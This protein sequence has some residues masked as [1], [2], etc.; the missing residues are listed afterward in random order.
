MPVNAVGF[1]LER[2]HMMKQFLLYMTLFALLLTT[3]L[4]SGCSKPSGEDTGD[5]NEQELP[6]KEANPEE[7]HY[8]FSCRSPKNQETILLYPGMEPS[9]AIEQLGEPLSYYE[10]PSCA[11]AGM[12]QIYTY[13]G[14]EL[15]VSLEEK[16]EEAILTLI[17]LTDDSFT[18]AEGIYIGSTVEEL[19]AEYGESDPESGEYHYAKGEMEL[20]FLTKSQLVISIEYRW[21]PEHKEP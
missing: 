1:C 2:N 17:R 20:A 15:T 18:T 9:S 13:S 10:A 6:S 4:F 8:L 11:L 7:T 5:E 16:Q 21:N 14:F 3:A 12:D 19:L